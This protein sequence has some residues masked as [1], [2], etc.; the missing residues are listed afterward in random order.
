M[1]LLKT[2][3]ALSRCISL[4]DFDLW[5][6]G[7]GDGDS[8]AEWAETLGDRVAIGSGAATNTGDGVSD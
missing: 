1:V 4:A 7:D 2:I 6:F 5:R 3:L 8:S